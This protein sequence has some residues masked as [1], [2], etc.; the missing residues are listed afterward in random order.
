M[1]KNKFYSLIALFLI[2]IL[3]GCT[4]SISM[5]G[6]IYESYEGKPLQNIEVSIDSSNKV[7]TN[8]DGAYEITNITTNPVHVAVNGGKRYRLFEDD[9]L[10][11]KGEN[12]RDFLIDSLH[13]L[14]ILEIDIVDP[15]SLEYEIEIGNSKDDI[16]QSAYVKSIPTEQSTSIVGSETG[17]DGITIDLEI[18]QIGFTGWSVDV[19]G[20]WNETI[21]PGYSLLRFDNIFQEEMIVATSFYKDINITFEEIDGTIMFEETPTRKFIADYKDLE[22]GFS[23]HMEIFVIEDGGYKGQIKAIHSFHNEKSGLQY[24]S[25][26]INSFDSVDEILPPIIVK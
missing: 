7:I 16:L 26:T 9:V 11:E 23:R 2:F 4:K 1:K 12:Y 13:P 21:E 20:N 3:I 17:L 10:L 25:I 6:Y 24:I 14:D 22:S 5:K 18:I 8:S 19:H 15:Y